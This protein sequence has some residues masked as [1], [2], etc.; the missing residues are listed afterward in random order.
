MH[1][2][3][4]EKIIFVK[5]DQYEE[6]FFFTAYAFEADGNEVKVQGL[7]TPELNEVGENNIVTTI[8]QC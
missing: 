3:V 5:A 6:L 1:E 7:S 4:L 8:F 2:L